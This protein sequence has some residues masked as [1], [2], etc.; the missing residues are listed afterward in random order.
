MP[1]LDPASFLPQL[2]WLALTFIPLYL[3][4][5]FV[6]L[7]RVSR[8]RDER[9]G[10]IS[11]DLQ[12]AE[13]LKQKADEAKAAYEAALAE[14]R[15]KAQDSLLANR[16]AL[17]SEVEGRMAEVTATLAAESDK[18]AATIR[19]AKTEAMASISKITADV[20]KDLVTRMT[21]VEL[22][23]AVVAKTVQAKLA[24]VQ[25]NQGAAQ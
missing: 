2:F 7:P 14:A 8:V 17:Q 10:R 21:G 5:H 25:A 18:A 19:T 20:C 6:A 12:E 1:Q 24:S 13:S 11:G 23:D 16:K 4:M 22:D 15:S 9:A 3:F